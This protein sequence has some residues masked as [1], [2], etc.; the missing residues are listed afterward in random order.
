MEWTKQEFRNFPWRHER[1]PFKIFVAGMLLKRTTSRAAHRIYEPFLEKYPT[2]QGIADTD[3]KELEEF[4]K[5]IGLNKQRAKGIK[6]AG[7]FIVQKLDGDFLEQFEE[8]I[9]IPHV[10]TYTAACILSFGM[11]I[12][13]PAIDTN[14]ERIISRF[15]KGVLGE[16]PRLDKVIEFSWDL[17]PRKEHVLFNYGLIDI[18]ARVCSYRGCSKENC[19]LHKN[20]DFFIK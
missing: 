8:L 1:T 7:E 2:L 14:G 20:C 16:R 18:G 12:P 3:I 13:I 19:P 5:P 4:L 17:L 6:E 15:F 9:L 10:G 11:N